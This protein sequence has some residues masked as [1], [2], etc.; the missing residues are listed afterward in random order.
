ML[1]TIV[2][3]VSLKPAEDGDAGR[4]KRPHSSAA[5]KSKQFLC[6]IKVPIS[7][8]TLY[9]NLFD[10]TQKLR[11]KDQGGI[12]LKRYSYVDASSGTDRRERI[13]YILSYWKVA[14]NRRKINSET[15][16]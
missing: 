1:P 13:Y 15:H 8:K 7:N 12:I 11:R 2:P 16:Q 3:E 14:R 10:I 9:Y 6:Y 4:W 5:V